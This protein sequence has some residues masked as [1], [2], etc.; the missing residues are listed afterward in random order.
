MGRSIDGLTLRLRR[1][2]G[3]FDRDDCLGILLVLVEVRKLS[4]LL[5]NVRMRIIHRR[6]V[7][8]VVEDPLSPVREC[9]LEGTQ[10]PPPFDEVLI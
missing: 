9:V 8:V 10:S 3:R 1:L 6:Q 2:C 5:R 7:E 4:W